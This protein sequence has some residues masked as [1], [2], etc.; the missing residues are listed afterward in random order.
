MDLERMI[1]SEWSQME[2]DKYHEITYIWNLKSDTN[3]YICKTEM[4]SQM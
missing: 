4:D 2:K 3:E 1:L